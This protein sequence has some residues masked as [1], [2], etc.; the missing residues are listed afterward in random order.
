[1][2]TVA[3]WLK[4]GWRWWTGELVAMVPPRLWRGPRGPVALVDAEGGIAVTRDGRPAIVPAGTAVVAALPADR[5]LVRTLSLPPLGDRDLARMVDLQIDRLMPFAPGT[6]L[7]DIASG[8]VTNGAREVRVAALPLATAVEADAA[9][10][11]AGLVPVA[12]RLASSEGRVAH[13]F[14]PALRAA[15]G[16]RDPRAGRRAWWRLVGLLFVLN[17]ALLIGLDTLALRNVERLVDGHAQAADGVRRARRRVLDEE[18]WRQALL[19]R[20]AARDPLAVVADIGRRAP[21]GVS[22]RRLTIAPEGIRVAGVARGGA[23][24]LGALR[25]GGRY[26]Q[27]RNAADVLAATPE[28]QPFDISFGWPARR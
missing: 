20:R 21:A 2:T 19:V 13:D 14:L 16:E 25:A 10:R 9:V 23:D 11:A 17:V 4:D 3:G 27:V 12:L 6:A 7:I 1:M 28:G 18:A 8:P 24:M 5:A 15:R 26:P 22:I